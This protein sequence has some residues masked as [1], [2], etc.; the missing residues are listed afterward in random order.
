M[1]REA[2]GLLA[3]VPPTLL[4]RE[5]PLPVLARFPPLLVLLRLEPLPFFLKL[6]ALPVLLGSP[7][8]GWAARVVVVVVA[9]LGEE[10]GVTDLPLV[11]D[12]EEVVNDWGRAMLDGR[13]CGLV[14][15]AVVVV[16]VVR[17]AAAVAGR[18]LAERGICLEG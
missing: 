8:A 3:P 18:S 17:L 11:L 5:L 2:G 7:L 13:G 16:V 14:V 6:E 4:F 12:L 15:G 9:D 1:L 10:T